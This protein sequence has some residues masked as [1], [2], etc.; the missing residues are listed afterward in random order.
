MGAFTVPAPGQ[1]QGLDEL[2]S[3]RGSVLGWVPPESPVDGGIATCVPAGSVSRAPV[4][5]SR[6]GSSLGS[7]GSEPAPSSE[8]EA[9]AGRGAQGARYSLQGPAGWGLGPVSCNCS[10]SRGPG[11]GREHKSPRPGCSS[12]PWPL[13]AEGG[14]GWRVNSGHLR[15]VHLFFFF[16]QGNASRRASGGSPKDHFGV[17]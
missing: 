10:G 2:R 11:G 5:S 16:A 7:C 1:M 12:W 14:W 17:S 3:V 8:P 4:V 15:G 9:S 6:A 13:H